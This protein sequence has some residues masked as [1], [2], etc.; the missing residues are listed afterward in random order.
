MDLCGF[1]RARLGVDVECMRKRGAPDIVVGSVG[2]FIV[3]RRSKK[4]VEI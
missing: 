1:L 2:I 4:E 3:R